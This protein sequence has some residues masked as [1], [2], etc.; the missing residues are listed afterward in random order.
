MEDAVGHGLVDTGAL[1]QP[2]G[3]LEAPPAPAS[4]ASATS[5]QGL[6]SQN[7]RNIVTLILL[8]L[9]CWL[10]LLGDTTARAQVTTLFGTL[11][12]YLFG[13]RAALKRPN[14]DA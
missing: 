4:Q 9:V 3:P 8:V 10:V 6:L 12:A 5:R 2:E 14:I 7:L 13:E 1:P 11:I